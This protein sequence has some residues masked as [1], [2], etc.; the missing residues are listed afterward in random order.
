MML[1]TSKY[2]HFIPYDER[3]Y[4]GYNFLYRT[5]IRIPNEAYPSVE[6]FMTL[7]QR[8]ESVASEAIVSAI[9]A[10]TMNLW[11]VSQCRLLITIIRWASAYKFRYN[12]SP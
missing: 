2:N 5:I 1:Q 12:R 7:L 10:A 11:V 9:V 3:F 4:I 6:K 8:N